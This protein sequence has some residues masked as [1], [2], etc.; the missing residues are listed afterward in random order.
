MNTSL[1]SNS[2]K[3][4]LKVSSRKMKRLDIS[5]NLISFQDLREMMQ[6]GSE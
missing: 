4:L 5:F 1:T 3:L 2:I 6:V